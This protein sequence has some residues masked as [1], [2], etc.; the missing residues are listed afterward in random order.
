MDPDTQYTP[1]VS[2]P[3]EGY[4][5][6]SSGK[7]KR[8]PW[9][10]LA[11]VVL[12][13]AIGFGSMK[14]WSGDDAAADQPMAEAQI[15]SEGFRPITITVKKGDDVMWVNKDAQPHQVYADQTLA[16]GL[17]SQEPLSE[18]DAYIYT[19]DKTGTYNYYDPLNPTTYK[20]TVVVE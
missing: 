20:G 4:N 18:G 13:V 19:F 16:P 2:T 11:V 10:A 7:K 17:D 8:W 1:Y 3:T 9:I 6:Y 12:A 15:T 14:F 5:D